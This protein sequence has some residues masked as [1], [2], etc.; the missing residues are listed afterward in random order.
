[1]K[2]NGISLRRLN[3]VMLIITVFLS[4]GL[5][6]AMKMTTKIFDE[7]DAYTE[8]FLEWR[9][10]SYELQKA[11]DYLTEQMQNFSVTGDRSFLDNYFKEAKE[12][13]RRENALNI[14]GQGHS[15]STA[16]L[17][18]SAAMNESVKLMDKE[19]YAAR[20]TVMAFDYDIKDFPEEIQNVKLKESD[21]A[22][23]VEEMK[24]TARQIMHGKEYHESKAIISSNMEKCLQ[25]LDIEM[26]VKQQENSDRLG[27][28][29]FLEHALTVSI[30]VVIIFIF[31][32][33][34]KLVILPLKNSVRIIRDEEDLPI[35]G[36]YEIQFLAKT[37]NIMR[38]TT[39]Q[40][41]EKLSYEV[42]HDK[43]TGLYNRRGYDS[44]LETADLENSALMLIDIDKFKMVNDTY[45]HD[46]GDRILIRVADTLFGHF[47]SQG[48]ICRIGGD[49][50]AVLMI[51]CDSS[52]KPVIRNK[53]E[54][55]NQVLSVKYGNDPTVSISA[56]VAFGEKGI[57]SESL[58]KNADNCLYEVKNGNKKIISFYQP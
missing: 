39:L 49:E 41:N 5:F 12:T 58:F 54:K 7:N 17:D 55:I 48:Y 2:K 14:L 40:R 34:Y 36:A 16:Y 31:L 45:G 19:Y 50:M 33:I 43:L 24:E 46:V 11:S 35:S 18:L 26:D 21:S 13:K 29:V 25:E 4:V 44:L 6:I 20:L 37:Y 57:T 15:R 52:I 23:T 8:Q 10:S 1:M 32:Y 51:Q 38:Q 47:K 27:R 28:Q 42:S 56:G 53:I 3:F 22:L 9:Q 30:I